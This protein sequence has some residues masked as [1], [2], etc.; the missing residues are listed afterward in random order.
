MWVK[1]IPIPPRLGNTQTA[2]IGTASAVLKRLENLSRLPDLP[3]DPLDHLRQIHYTPVTE[4]HKLFL[5]QPFFPI[6]STT[7]PPPQA[8]ARSGGGGTSEEI[9]ST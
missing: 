7:W 6:K 1:K 2:R 4:I 5:V 8:V 3:G 9:L